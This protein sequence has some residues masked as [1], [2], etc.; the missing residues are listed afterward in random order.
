MSFFK[1]PNYW[2]GKE[3]GNLQY[4]FAL[5]GCKNPDQTRGIFNQFLI[6]E[7]REDKKVLEAMGDKL[8]IRYS[9][10]QV[11]GLGFNKTRDQK[12]QVRVNNKEVYLLTF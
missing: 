12:I 2:D 7:L 5:E 11:S 10:T 1:S 8:L 6:P 9:D 3:I 4:I